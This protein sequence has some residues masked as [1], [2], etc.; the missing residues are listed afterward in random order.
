MYSKNGVKP[1]FV[2]SEFRHL[3]TKALG[4]TR[5]LFDVARVEKTSFFYNFYGFGGIRS[6]QPTKTATLTPMV[7]LQTAPTS[8]VDKSYLIQNT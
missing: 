5:S 3:T 7:W 6:T 4:F 2:S 1:N 8:E